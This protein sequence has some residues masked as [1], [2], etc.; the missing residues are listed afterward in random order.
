MP[1]EI[2]QQ[3]AGVELSINYDERYHMVEL[4]PIK[5]LDKVMS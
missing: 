1:G 5:Y 3:L 2:R 4:Q